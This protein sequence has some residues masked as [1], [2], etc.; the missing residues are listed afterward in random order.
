MEDPKPLHQLSIFN[1]SF[2]T[3]TTAS[4]GPTGPSGEPLCGNTGE[5]GQT[6]N[7]GPEGHTGVDGPQGVDGSTGVTGT[8]YVET[9][10]T[11]STYQ[12]ATGTTSNK[13]NQILQ[14][15]L[16]DTFTT[17][18]TSFVSTPL[19]VT[20][21]PKANT[22]KFLILCNAKF[23]SASPILGSP[24]YY[25]STQAYL[26]R[27]GTPIYLA[28]ANGNVTVTSF[29]QRGVKYLGGGTNS[30]LDDAFCC[31]YDSPDTANAITYGLYMRANNSLGNVYIN[32]SFTDSNSGTYPRSAS[33][34]I[35]MEILP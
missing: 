29:G 6:G 27:D 7:T 1:T 2:F 32:R 24:P 14:S 30:S 20:I 26:T 34:L 8:Y 33:S 19:S 9:G 28:N 23:G 10:P 22:S 25:A 12:G 13:L 4:I 15:V 35:V 17:N 11:G 16:I 3:D 31:Y 18:S 21:S 5:T